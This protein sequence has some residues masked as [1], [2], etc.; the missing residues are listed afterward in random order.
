MRCM[1]LDPYITAMA[2]DDVFAQRQTYAIAAYFGGKKPAEYALLI[3]GIDARTVIG[4]LQH[5]ARAFRTR[6]YT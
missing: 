6:T 4:Y 1:S 5:Y 2:C 3:A